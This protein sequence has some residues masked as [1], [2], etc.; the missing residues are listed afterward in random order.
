MA[1]GLQLHVAGLAVAA[2][3]VGLRLHAACLAAPAPAVGLRLHAAAL[4]VGLHAAALA[5]GLRFHAAAL[6][7][8]G[9]L[10]ADAYADLRAACVLGH[11]L[12]LG[13]RVASALLA[14]LLVTRFVASA[15][16]LVACALIT[17]ALL[18]CDKIILMGNPKTFE[19]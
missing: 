19:F 16:A 18:V 8:V 7:A 4:A 17:D 6:L 15:A 10:A 11:L 1:V 3:A 14:L 12:A 5:V 9:L 2:L 13:P